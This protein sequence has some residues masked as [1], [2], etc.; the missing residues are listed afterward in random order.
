MKLNYNRLQI[1]QKFVN[2]FQFYFLEEEKIIH[3]R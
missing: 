1:Y 3:Q 2:I